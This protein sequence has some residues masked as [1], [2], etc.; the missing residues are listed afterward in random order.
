MQLEHGLISLLFAIAVVHSVSLQDSKCGY[1]SEDQFLIMNAFAIPTEHQWLAGI[2]YMNG[3]EM[4]LQNNGCV[5]VLI[6]KRNVLAP[7]HCFLQYDGHVE[8]FSVLLGV[9]NKSSS[10]GDASCD[11]NG[12]CVLPAQDIPVKEIA[13]Y[14][15]Y[16]PL[17]L[18]HDLAV[19]TLQRDAQLTPNVMPICM[20]PPSKVNETLVGQLFVVA[21]LPIKDELKHKAY[22]HIHSRSYCQKEHSSLLSSS[23][24]VCGYQDKSMM[25]HLGA[26]LVG[27]HVKMDA[28]QSYYLVGLLLDEKENVDGEDSVAASFLDVRPYL[29]FIN[30]NADFLII[31]D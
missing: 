25:Y 10:L 14:P 5:G 18:K 22:V 4:K 17:T 3:Q 7:A 11:R 29:K 26:P 31:S 27:I 23:N 15:E 1:I 6:S 12:F 21:G 20:P 9:W 24:T 13:I 28:P 8:V 19:L 16:D 2:T 30:R